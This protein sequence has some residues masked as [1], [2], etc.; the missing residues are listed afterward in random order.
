MRTKDDDAHHPNSR[1]LPIN[2]PHTSSHNG[3]DESK[4]VA[5]SGGSRKNSNDDTRNVQQHDNHYSTVPHGDE[6]RSSSQSSMVPH[7]N[8]SSAS[9]SPQSSLA[10]Q[11]ITPHNIP[12]GS[13]GLSIEM[14]PNGRGARITKISEACSISNEVS[15]G[16]VIVTID[17]LKIRS[18]KDFGRNNHTIRTL[19]IV[20]KTKK[21]PVSSIGTTWRVKE[22]Q[23]T[24]GCVLRYGDDCWSFISTLLNRSSEAIS[25]RWYGK[26]KKLVRGLSPDEIAASMAAAEVAVSAAGTNTQKQAAELERKWK[27]LAEEAEAELKKTEAAPKTIVRP[28]WSAYPMENITEPH[29]NDVLCGR[30]GRDRGS[31]KWRGNEAFCELVNRNECDYLG[32]SKHERSVLAMRIVQAVRAQSPPGRFLE[33]DKLTE[34]WTDIGDDMARKKTAMAL[35]SK[36]KRQKQNA[37]VLA[38]REA[39]AKLHEDGKEEEAEKMERL[40][41]ELYAK[42]KDGRHKAYRDNKVLYRSPKWKEIRR[43]DLFSDLG[44]YLSKL[45]PRDGSGISEEGKEAAKD[46]LRRYEMNKTACL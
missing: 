45:K 17:D 2:L 34:T 1:R 44:K 18:S 29:K 32:C 14:I 38:T 42:S 35:L 33:H 36:A 39:S 9:S 31:N 16:D 26:L 15:V 28:E 30:G 21:K 43:S 37:E 8:S 13:I 46:F 25:A 27:E 19:G 11:H 22:E 12:R 41:D 3:N 4:E 6:S 23:L 5:S 7:G 24:M 20:H 10:E 40:A